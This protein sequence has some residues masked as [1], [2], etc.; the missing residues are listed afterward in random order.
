MIAHVQHKQNELA[1]LCRKYKVRVL[2]LFGSAATELGFDPETSDLD[3]LVEFEP[4]DNMGPADQY[5]GL[6]EDLK[7]LFGREVH[8]V[9]NRSLRNPYFIESVNATRQSLYAS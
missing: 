4:T 5:F 8:L 9:T 2:D 1:G 7:S 3:F 6:L